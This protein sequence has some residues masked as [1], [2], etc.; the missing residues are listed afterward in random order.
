M[1]NSIIESAILKTLLKGEIVVLPDLG[2]LEVVSIS[3][4]RSVL[5]R[6]IKSKKENYSQEGYN[7]IFEGLARSLTE[8]RMISIENIGSFTLISNSENEK[9]V[10]FIPSSELRLKIN[11]STTSLSET[12][13]IIS[14]PKLDTT[15]VSQKKIDLSPTIGKET[16]SPEKILKSI[17]EPREIDSLQY[18]DFQSERNLDELPIKSKDKIDLNEIDIPKITDEQ[19]SEERNDINVEVSVHDK[20][21]RDS[22]TTISSE[23]DY[24]VP[25]LEKPEKKKYFLSIPVVAWRVIALVIVGIAIVY[26]F[27]KNNTEQSVD[28]ETGIWIPPDN[29]NPLDPNMT[30]NLLDLAEKEYG[31]KVF[32]VYI[33]EANSGKINSPTGIS[34]QIPITIPDLS[35]MNIN[36]KDSLEI[37]KALIKGEEIL[38][39]R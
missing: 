8:K 31:N 10:S 20:K 18:V 13:E 32:W 17:E 3:G 37:E 26:V 29:N 1:D 24:T 22:I 14:P 7:Q 5:F 38:N 11:S 16:I 35:E 6:N 9:R 34:P 36:P 4:K 21:E 28:V 33:F 12:K 2:Y 30:I 25:P 15:K 23:R 39:S 27:N 19:K